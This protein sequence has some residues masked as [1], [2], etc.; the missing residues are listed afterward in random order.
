MKLEDLARVM[1]SLGYTHESFEGGHNFFS[2]SGELDAALRVR[3]E[4]VELSVPWG[5]HS[6][7]WKTTLAECSVAW[8]ENAFAEMEAEYAGLVREIQKT[9]RT[10]LSLDPTSL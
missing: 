1:V 9:R 3:G 7:T 10:L 2:R 8:L 5:A 4:E 6:L